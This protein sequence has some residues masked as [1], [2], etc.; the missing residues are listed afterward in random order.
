LLYLGAV[1]PCPFDRNGEAM[2]C[3]YCP[4]CRREKEA[5]RLKSDPLDWRYDLRYLSTMTKPIW[6]YPLQRGMALDDPNL[7]YLIEREYAA[8]VGTEG[9]VI[10]ERGRAVLAQIVF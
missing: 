9:F 1:W 7:R 3:P 2:G 10:T 8:P 5:S 4:H 6:G